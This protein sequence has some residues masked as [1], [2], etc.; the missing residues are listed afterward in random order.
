[1]G[2]V[3]VSV[4]NSKEALYYESKD[5]YVLCKLCP[6]NCRI[7]EN[8]TGFCMVRKNI[9]GKLYSLN[10]ERISSIA[11]DPIE[12]KPLYHFNKGTSILSIGSLGCNFSC[13]FCQ[14]YSISREI[15]FSNVRK[16]SSDEII[17]IALENKLT[18]IAYTYNEPTVFFEMVLDTCKA[19]RKHNISNVLV[20]NGYISKNPF[21]ELAPYINAMN[22]DVK[23]YDDAL[24]YDICHGHLIPV[25]NTIKIAKTHN[26]HMELTCLI[27]PTLFADIKLCGSFFEQ[28]E[29]AA[30]NVVIHLSRYFPRYEYFEPSTDINCML[31][32]QAVAKKYFSYV[33]L[34][35]V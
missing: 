7:K 3:I 5:K 29:A 26:I 23:S 10:Y 24:Y 1:M 25:L 17:K 14:N 28:L 35:N 6:H 16:Y 12:K 20:T 2:G 30:G 15:D 4:N 32:I 31:Q 27:V 9:K 19:A 21:E 13:K 11:I 33:Y 22:I 18:S 8:E 34:G